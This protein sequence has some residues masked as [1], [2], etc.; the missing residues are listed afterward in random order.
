MKDLFQNLNEEQIVAVKSEQHTLVVACPGSG[1]TRV[2]THKVGYELQKLTSSK[3]R[4]LALTHTN[5]AADEIA[6]RIEQL[7]ILN[8]QLWSGTIHAFCTEWILRPYSGYCEITKFGF[9]IADPEFFD[10][11]T[12]RLNNGKDLYGTLRFDILGN[13]IETDEKKKQIILCAYNNFRDQRYLTFDDI[14]YQ[15][16]CLLRDN[17][18]IAD[19]LAKVFKWICVD[20][21]QDTQEL[22]YQILHLIIRGG[23]KKSKIFYVGDPTN[24]FIM[25]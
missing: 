14:L 7:D 16:Y 11:E 6:D 5:V 17:S 4:I 2:L 12:K 19:S 18:F 24:L 25:V 1:K 22:Q 9:T 20:E 8:S 10:E 13:L 21:Y 23:E 15:T 3:Q